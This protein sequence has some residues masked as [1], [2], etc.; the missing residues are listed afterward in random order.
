VYHSSG[1]DLHLVGSLRFADDRLATVEAG[2]VSALQQTYTVIGTDGTVELPHDAFIP[3]E[4]DA[5]LTVRGKDEE[6]GREQVVS[7]A[8]QYQLMVEHFADAVLGKTDLRFSPDDSVGN[9]KVLDALAAA[10]RNGETV[11]LS[12][13]GW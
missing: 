12:G 10:A 2:F 6:Q 3:W 11:G 8:D 1:V 7:G 13:G 9:M 5:V 4:K